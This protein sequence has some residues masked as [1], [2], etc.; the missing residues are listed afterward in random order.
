[1]QISSLRPTQSRLMLQDL[2]LISIMGILAACG[3]IYQY[4]F[5]HY[6][7]RVL[8][9][10]EHTIFSMIGLMIVSMGVGSLAAKYVKCPYSGFAWIEN[11]VALLGGLGIFLIS[12]LFALAV[13]LPQQLA[14][15]FH[16]PPD[17]VPQGGLIVWVERL[18]YISPFILACIL[19]ALIGMEIPFI[20]RI[21]NDLYGQYL[22]H[23]I[24]TL[25]GV[26]YLGAGVGA[27]LFILYM[28]KMSPEKAALMTAG[29]NLCISLIFLLWMFKRIKKVFFLLTIHIAFLSTFCGLI[30]WGNDWKSLMEQILYEDKVVLSLETEFQHIT[31][32]EGKAAHNAPPVYTLFLNG[33][34]QF[35]SEDEHI[36]HSFLVHPAF[37]ASP[38]HH[39]VLVIGGG[40]GLALREIYK[41]SPSQVTLLELDQQMVELFKHPYSQKGKIINQSLIDLNQS[42]F[43][44]P[45]LNVIYGDAFNTAKG[46]T[47]LNE[48]FD[49]IIVDLPDPSHP[50]LNKLYSVEFYRTLKRLLNADGVISIQSTSPYHAKKAFLTVGVTLKEAGFKTVHRMHHNVPSFGQW[51]WTLGVLQGRSPAQ[52]IKAFNGP[53]PQPN[54]LTPSFVQAAFEFP[55]DYFSI[56]KELVANRLDNH[57]MYLHHQHAWLKDTGYDGDDRRHNMS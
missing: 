37:M 20:A 30:M 17:L 18:A 29:I 10:M 4:L 24:G 57:M 44:D 43:L 52:R 51:G 5:S 39:K 3:L 38:Y 21:R 31:L 23:N 35:S 1:M 27:A 2:L 25:Y 54:W 36:Y 47:A 11:F 28:L 9:I 56:E 50:D 33:H 41:W 42:S 22:E 48:R 32:T 15:N 7:G 26:D 8:G 40:D 46:L 13:I 53:L 16:L 34:T 12:G 49:I 45:R 6:A 14:L 19:G 55:C